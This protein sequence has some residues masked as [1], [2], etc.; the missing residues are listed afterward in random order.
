MKLKNVKDNILPDVIKLNADPA[1]V[2]SKT[3]YVVACE[4]EAN[5][6]VCIHGGFRLQVPSLAEALCI[7]TAMFHILHVEFPSPAAGVFRFISECFAIRD[8]EATIS[9][10][11]KEILLKYKLL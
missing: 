5:Y 10:T 4:K 9:K 11:Q 2:A 3:G 6:Y 8:P 1:V 7:T